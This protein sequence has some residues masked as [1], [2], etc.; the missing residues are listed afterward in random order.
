MKTWKIITTA[1]LAVAAVALLTTS[2]YGMG[3]MGGGYAEAT[4]EE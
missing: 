4:E 1:I 2:V 3:M